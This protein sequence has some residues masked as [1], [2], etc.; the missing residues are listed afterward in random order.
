MSRANQFRGTRVDETRPGAR[1]LSKERA[2]LWHI[3]NL[4]MWE[5]TQRL[6][7]GSVP[8]RLFHVIKSTELF[9]ELSGFSL[10][11]KRVKRWKE[12]ERERATRNQRAAEKREGKKEEKGRRVGESWWRKGPSKEHEAEK[13]AKRER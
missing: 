6:G 2:L 12:T 13:E 4:V 5:W 1:R 8:P 11:E 10:G 7:P 9:S 3:R